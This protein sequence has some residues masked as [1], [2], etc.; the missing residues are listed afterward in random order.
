VWAHEDG[1]VPHPDRLTSEFAKFCEGLDLSPVGLHGLRHSFAAVAIAAGVAPY[2]LSRALGH[3]QVAFT[4]DRYGHLF[5]N[6]LDEEMGKISRLL[7][8]A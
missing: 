5:D 8:T 3:T 4:Y 1:S 7:E 6:G 2:S